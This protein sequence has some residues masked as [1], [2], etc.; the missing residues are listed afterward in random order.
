LPP[1]EYVALLQ[2]EQLLLLIRMKLGRQL[3]QVGLPQA[4]QP[5]AQHSVACPPAEY[6]PSGHA[7]QLLLFSE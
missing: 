1:F 4:A 6:S 5:K 7:A 2:A 3:L